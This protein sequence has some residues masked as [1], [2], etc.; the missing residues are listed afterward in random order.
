MSVKVGFVPQRPGIG[1][2]RDEVA[3][4]RAYYYDLE[5]RMVVD[6]AIVAPALVTAVRRMLAAWHGVQAAAREGSTAAM[7]I[8][9][10]WP[11]QARQSG[12][13]SR[14]WARR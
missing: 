1:C 4:Q 12:S 14:R 8:A 7:R 2:L 13:L 10:Q 6:G 9:G 3:R 11:P 5:R